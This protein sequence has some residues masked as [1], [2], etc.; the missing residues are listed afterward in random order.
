MP[1]P[2]NQKKHVVVTL[3]LGKNAFPCRKGLG[4]LHLRSFLEM[5]INFF[6]RETGFPGIRNLNNFQGK[7]SHVIVS[8]N[9]TIKVTLLG[10]SGTL[11]VWGNYSRN[12]SEI[13][14]YMCCLQVLKLSV[15][16]Y[17][18]I[19]CPKQISGRKEKAK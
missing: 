10:L 7:A 3:T 15:C 2:I 1:R 13:T 4:Y 19:Y 12:I 14:C 6:L 17:F 18:E 16:L 5:I 11:A 8:R 9:R